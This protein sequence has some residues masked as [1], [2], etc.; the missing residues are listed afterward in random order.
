MPSDRDSALRALDYL[1]EVDK[2]GGCALKWHLERIAGNSDNFRRWE[3]RLV[4]DWKLLEK[5]KQGDKECY[6][7]TRRGEKIHASLK[8]WGDLGPIYQELVRPRLR[9]SSW[10]PP[11]GA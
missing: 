6:S 9:P 5:V 4:T 11:Q 7:K 2:Q 8:D 1:N 10:Y 3:A